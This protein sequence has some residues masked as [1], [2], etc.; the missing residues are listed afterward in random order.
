M[1]AC[2]YLG[3]EESVAPKHKSAKNKLTLLPGRYLAGDFKFK[4]ILTY[5]RKSQSVERK[6]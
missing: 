1:P 3:K 4:P 6:T 5:N 2:T